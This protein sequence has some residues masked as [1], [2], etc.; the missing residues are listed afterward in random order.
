MKLL[1]SKV[2]EYLEILRSDA[3]AP[4]GGS[5]SALAGAQAMA[6]TTMVCG[7]TIGNA[8]YQASE[9]ICKEVKAKAEDL[10]E[11]FSIAVDK[12]TEAFHLVSNA[13]KMPKGTEEEKV[14]RSAAIA[15][16]TVEATKVPF[17]VMKMCWEGIQLIQKIAGKT[18][19]NAASDLGVAILNLS[20]GMKGAWLNVKINVPGIKDKAYAEE[21]FSEGEKMWVNC[22]KLAA[23]LFVET[24]KTI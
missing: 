14:A 10:F 24:E 8:K 20:A 4:G 12:D 13:Y 1:D 19:T 11:K 16:G 3:P 17:E 9:E 7:L 22:E 5:V 21:V 18:N 15:A 2:S 23:E 6:L